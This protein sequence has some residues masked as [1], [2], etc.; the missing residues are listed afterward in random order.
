[1]IISPVEI[2][3]HITYSFKRPPMASRSTL[4]TSDWGIVGIGLGEQGGD[5]MVHIT[6]NAFCCL[7]RMLL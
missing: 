5:V 1:M 4:G 3:T 7:T 6:K 2:L